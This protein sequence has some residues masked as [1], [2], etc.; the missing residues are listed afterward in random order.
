[1]PTEALFKLLRKTLAL[2]I[3]F[4][5][6]KNKTKLFS[7]NKT[8]TSLRRKRTSN[9][10]YFFLFLFFFCTYEKLFHKFNFVLFQRNQYL[11]SKI[12]FICSFTFRSVLTPHCI[13]CQLMGC[14]QAYLFC[15]ASLCPLARTEHT[16]D[17][18]VFFWL[19]HWG[20][21]VFEGGRGVGWII[22]LCLDQTLRIWLGTQFSRPTP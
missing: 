8:R 17:F 22:F 18:L 3:A 13:N 10:L 20:K 5:L 6:H 19:Y 12:F 7:I 16:S 14:C 11:K 21:R 1:M 9:I 15:L 4:S 2:S